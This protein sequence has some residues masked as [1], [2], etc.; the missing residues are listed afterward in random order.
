MSNLFM[1][2]YYE[3]LEEQYLEYENLTLL[4]PFLHI[5]KNYLCKM[6]LES[7]LQALLL[8]TPCILLYLLF[9]I[10]IYI[11]LSFLP[12]TQNFFIA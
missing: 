2:N 9:R 10:H 1:K 5:C 4:S 3:N 8:N 7:I 11:Q 12:R 6:I